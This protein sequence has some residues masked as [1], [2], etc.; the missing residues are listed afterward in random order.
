M[1]ITGSV[2]NGVVVLPEG[3]HLPEGVTVY[4]TL[5]S[6]ADAA[7]KSGERVKLPIFESKGTPFGDLS[8]DEIADILD[9]EDA[10]R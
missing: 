5:A 3:T 9:R 1:V 2:Q 8:N 10:S 7:R 4:V 6:E